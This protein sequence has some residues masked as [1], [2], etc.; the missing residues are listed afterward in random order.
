MSIFQMFFK[1]RRQ[2]FEYITLHSSVY[3]TEVLHVGIPLLWVDALV[4]Y[5]S[6]LSGVFD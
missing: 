2:V 4:L 3:C 1:I 5:N 6:T